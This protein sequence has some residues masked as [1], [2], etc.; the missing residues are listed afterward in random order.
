MGFH[1]HNNSNIAKK[2]LSFNSLVKKA[3]VDIPPQE[4]DY[5]E[6]TQ[7][8]STHKA[9]QVK[10]Y[11]S[12]MAAEFSSRHPFQ[13]RVCKAFNRKNL[14]ANFDWTSILIDV[15]KRLPFVVIFIILLSSA[16]I[17]FTY[18]EWTGKQTYV[19]TSKLLYKEIKFESKQILPTS[20]SLAM[21]KHK[22]LL[23][24]ALSTLPEYQSVND[25]KSVINVTF[26]K[27]S[28]LINIEVNTA[29]KEQSIKT[30]NTLSDLAIQTSQNYYYRHFQEKF[31]NLSKQVKLAEQ[32][33]IVQDRLIAEAIKKNGVLKPREQYRII[34]EAMS[35]QQRNLLEAQIDYSKQQVQLDVLKSEYE[36]MPEEVVRNSYEDNP[37]KAQL[38]NTKMSLLS[39]QS[40][41]GE[42][43]PKILAIQEKI[44]GL[45]KQLA[46]Q[47]IKSTLQK[48]YMPNLKKQEVYMEIARSQG[49][50]KSAKNRIDSIEMNL[51]IQKIELYEVP[52]K[53]MKLDDT[54]RKREATAELLDVLR[55]KQQDVEIM[56][57]SEIKDMVLYEQADQANL[58]QPVKLLAI[59]P[60]AFVCSLILS[61]VYLLINCVLDQS[62]KTKKHL[63][64]NFTIPCVMQLAENHDFEKHLYK[65]FIDL[66]GVNTNKHFNNIICL[67]SQNE[68]EATADLV[69]CLAA[70]NQKVLVCTYSHTTQTS[71]VLDK[72][73]P[74]WEIIV[75][76]GT[77]GKTV[78]T[79][80]ITI[81]SQVIVRGLLDRLK[82]LSFEYD[83]IIVSLESEEID[84]THLGLINF[85]DWYFYVVDACETKRTNLI[86][87]L[88]EMEFKGVCPEGFILD[89]VK[90]KLL[91][92]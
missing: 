59:A 38:T 36:K 81:E 39:A 51:E 63:D 91:Q 54:L 23:G 47:D 37:L 64:I 25:L 19:S 30:T 14:F 92:V 16:G 7:R 69:K 3:G 68:C 5:K 45:K 9:S 12:D 76:N 44:T 70:K 43:N 71:E 72:Q 40:I 10:E 79:A 31:S 46:S 11:S 56:M 62:I 32:D 78:D 42:G 6:N 85:A 83:F 82:K 29:N 89:N 90:E 61:L 87:K 22:K 80:H 21:L 13:D 65:D 74:N 20:T 66:V 60:G 75:E 35:L 1:K 15:K 57:N 18:S 49:K 41:Y 28:K 88:K 2:P 33:M 52:E 26:D 67:Q 17:Y 53:E 58:I 48:V 86:Q 24:N 8:S 84:K 77:D 34:M 50:L 4:Q 73:A 27:K 55:K